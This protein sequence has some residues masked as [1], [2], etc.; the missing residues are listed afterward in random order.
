MGV[1]ETGDDTPHPIEHIGDIPLTHVG[2]KGIMRNFLHVLT[3]T[4][5]LVFVRQIVDQ[6]MQVRFT[7]HDCFIE[8]EGRTIVRGH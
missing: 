5:N 4:K 2:Q 6:G 7:H 1:I 8:D 3:I